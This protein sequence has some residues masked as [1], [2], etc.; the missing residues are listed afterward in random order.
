LNNHFDTFL[1]KITSPNLHD[2]IKRNGLRALQFVEIP[3]KYQGTIMDI[4]FQYLESPKETVAV[5]V[6]ALYILAKLAKVYPE[7]IQEI[8]LLIEMQIDNQTAGFKSAVK[9]VS[10]ELKF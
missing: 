1:K 2:G 9:T 6:F 5:K 7:L 10:K 3:E 4:C 8:R